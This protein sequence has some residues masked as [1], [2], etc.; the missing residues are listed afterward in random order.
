[1]QFL[2]GILEK[3]HYKLLTKFLQGKPNGLNSNKRV[4][5]NSGLLE[6]VNLEFSRPIVSGFLTIMKSIESHFSNAYGILITVCFSHLTFIHLH[7]LTFPFHT[8]FA[9]KLALN[10]F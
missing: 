8:Y 1:M 3:E 5:H 4:V 10:Y 7:V 9:T 2:L 6:T